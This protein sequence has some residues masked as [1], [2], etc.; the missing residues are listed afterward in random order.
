[1]HVDKSIHVECVRKPV[2]VKINLV[3]GMLD[4]VTTN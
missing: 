4:A 3:P 2:D 1:M